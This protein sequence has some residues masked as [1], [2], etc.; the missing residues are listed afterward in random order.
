[1]RYTGLYLRFSAWRERHRTLIACVLPAFVAVL[2]VLTQLGNGRHKLHDTCYGVVYV[3]LASVAFGYLAHM[4]LLKIDARRRNAS[5]R[6]TA[7]NGGRARHPAKAG[8][9]GRPPSVS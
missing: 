2:L 1:M 3:L 7:P 8:V 9:S 4:A 6:S 5:E